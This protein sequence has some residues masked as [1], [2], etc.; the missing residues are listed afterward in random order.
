MI[1]SF[2]AAQ[3]IEMLCGLNLTRHLKMFHVE[4]LEYLC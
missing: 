3:A 2:I 1:M 4:Q